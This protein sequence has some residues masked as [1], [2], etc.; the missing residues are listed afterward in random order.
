M[1]KNHLD[2][3]EKFIAHILDTSA[4]FARAKTLPQRTGAAFNFYL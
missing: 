3:P 4:P 2:K 1:R